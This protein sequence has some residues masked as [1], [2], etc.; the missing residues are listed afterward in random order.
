MPKSADM[1]LLV[2]GAILLAAGLF[3]GGTKIFS[4]EI[5]PGF[6]GKIARITALVLG[7]MMLG[8]GLYLALLKPE[9]A[10]PQPNAGAPIAPSAA[11]QAF[12]LTIKQQWETKKQ[13]SN[14]DDD[15]LRSSFKRHN[16]ESLGLTLP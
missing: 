11:S 3:G 2:F 5:P 16:C 14:Q 4:V 12:C 7:L 15:A 6:G 10:L 9:R 8:A 1:I 13:W